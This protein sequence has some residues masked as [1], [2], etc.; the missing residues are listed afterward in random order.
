MYEFKKSI[1]L[2]NLNV[3]KELDDTYRN[4]FKNHTFFWVAHTFS[5]IM[6]GSPFWDSVDYN[7]LSAA[8]SKWSY[9]C[10]PHSFWRC[11]IGYVPG[12]S[13]I[14]H[15]EL[16]SSNLIESVVKFWCLYSFGVV[17]K[18]ENLRK[19]GAVT[20]TLSMEMA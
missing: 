18:R 11:S 17:E 12:V 15:S 16:E 6:K 9:P 7:K 8:Q 13:C 3:R 1:L 19:R 4:L 2:N 20:T 10:I 5:F 14:N